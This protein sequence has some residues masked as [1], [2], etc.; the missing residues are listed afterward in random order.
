VAT[1]PHEFLFIGD[2]NLR[3]D[4][5]DDS[6]VKQ[7]LAVI[8]AVK[9]CFNASLIVSSSSNPL[10]LWNSVNTLLERKPTPLLLSLASSQSLSQMFAT[11][12][13]DKI[14]KLHTALKSSTTISSFYIP[15]KTLLL[16]CFTLFSENEVSKIISHSPNSFSDLDRVA[17]SLSTTLQENEPG[18]VFQVD[19]HSNWLNLQQWKAC[20]IHVV[21]KITSRLE[22]EHRTGHERS[23][24]EPI[25]CRRSSLLK[26]HT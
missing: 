8:I 25:C 3:F 9:K 18:D 16:S 13:S 1:T 12:F 7:F 26:H 21:W 22:E 14:L 4:H 24:T 19:L 10:K 11:F 6:Q 5:P 23:S 17:T 15:P 20:P 2:F